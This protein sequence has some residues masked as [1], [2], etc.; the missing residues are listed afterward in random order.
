[1]KEFGQSLALD[2]IK[3]VAALP[4]RSN[5]VKTIRIEI[6]NDGR[7]SKNIKS[8]LGGTISTK[9]KQKIAKLVKAELE[10][11]QWPISKTIID[12]MVQKHAS[13]TDAINVIEPICDGIKMGLKVDDQ[14]FSI[15][16]LDWEVVKKDPKIFVQISTEA[17]ISQR[18]CNSCWQIRPVS[19]FSKNKWAIQGVH[20][21]CLVCT[22]FLSAK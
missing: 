7:F 15:G 12:I 16:M 3:G 17:Q 2:S 8:Q 21:T 6:L 18:V 4:I 13:R 14:W 20:H 9:S 10:N 22:N 5:M 11:Y 1:M 19:E